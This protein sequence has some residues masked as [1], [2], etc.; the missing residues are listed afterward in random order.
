MRGMYRSTAE[1]LA[2][3]PTVLVFSS[4]RILSNGVV[5]AASGRSTRETWRLIV[6]SRFRPHDLKCSRSRFAEQRF[7]K[8]DAGRCREAGIEKRNQSR[9]VPFKD[10]SEPRE[11]ADGRPRI[12]RSRIRVEHVADSRFELIRT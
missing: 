11:Q 5:D 10:G 6:D 4:I 7:I 12:R 1:K 9:S 2:V 3:G 8:I